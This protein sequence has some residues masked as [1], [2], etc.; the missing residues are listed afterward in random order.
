VSTKLQRLYKRAV[1]TYHKV[2][3][4]TCLKWMM[5][6]TKSVS[7]GIR[8]PARNFD[9]LRH[10]LE[11]RS[12]TLRCSVISQKEMQICPRPCHEGTRGEQRCGSTHS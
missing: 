1:V 11:A 4:R 5:K 8:P 3:Y 7:R 9:P 2:Q 10:K 6:T 12:H